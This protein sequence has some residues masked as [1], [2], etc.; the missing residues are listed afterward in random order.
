MSNTQAEATAEEALRVVGR[1]LEAEGMP[2][3]TAE[4][5]G[6]AVHVVA[7][8]LAP[9][10]GTALVLEGPAGTGKTTATGSVAPAP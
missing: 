7:T 10:D 1:I 5:H 8:A 2:P 9:E 3:L 4:Q 6:Y